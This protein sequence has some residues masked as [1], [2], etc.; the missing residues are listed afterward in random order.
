MAC[1]WPAIDSRMYG[2][3]C[4][5]QQAAAG[6]RWTGRLAVPQL[7][8]LPAAQLTPLYLPRPAGPAPF[9]APFTLTERTAPHTPLIGRHRCLTKPKYLI[10]AGNNVCP[11]LRRALIFSVNGRPAR[12]GEVGSKRGRNWLGSLCGRLR[13]GA[14]LFRRVAGSGQVGQGSSL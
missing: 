5:T 13:P 8:Q 12:V 3:Q 4:R 1:D 9:T 11:Q 7:P 6:G 2:G 10:A 14:A